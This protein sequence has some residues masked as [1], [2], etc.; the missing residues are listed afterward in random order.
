[1]KKQ[2]LIAA[3]AATM[4]TAA[5]ADISISGNAKYEYINQEVGS[6]ESTNKGNTEVNLKVTGKTGDTTIVVSQEFSEASGNVTD[7]GGAVASN[8]DI[9]DMYIA[10]KIGDVNL[11]F[12]NW[13]GS[14]TANT[15]NILKL[16]KVL[17]LVYG[18]FQVM[19]LLMVLRFLVMLLVLILVLKSLQK[20]I[21]QLDFL[22]I[23]RVLIFF[24]KT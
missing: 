22:V 21:L 20:L 8:L 14:L 1:M 2:L 10:T 15:G 7:S 4:G 18:L 24:M 13:A 11:K 3:V 23:T 6:A 16:F 17:K 19:V 12:G 9:E 5:I